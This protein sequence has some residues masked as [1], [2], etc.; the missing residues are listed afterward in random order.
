MSATAGAGHL[1]RFI[2]R[3]ERR[4]LPFWL[5]GA[6][7]VVAYQ[8]IGSQAIYDTPEKLA[9][10]Q[11]TFGGNPAMVA[12]AGP[13]E[14]LATIGGEV[15]FEMFAYLAIL[16]A[17]MNMFLVGRNTRVEEETGRVELI[18]STQ[19]GRRAPLAAALA[20]A[21]LS[22]VSLALLVFLAAAGTGLPVSGSALLGVAAAS[23]GIFFAGLTAVAVQVFESARAAY[24]AVAAALGLAFFLRA[25]GDGGDGTASW[26][27]PIGWGQR[28][29]PFVAD[30]WWP[31]VLPL[32]ISAALV[33]VAVALLDRRDVG[34]GLVAA[35][36]GPATASRVL[37]TP[38]GLAV[39]L[40]RGPLIGWGIGLLV[41]GIAYGSFAESIEQ[42]IVDNPDIAEIF[43][44]ASGIVD[45]YLGFT[46][47]ALALLAGAYGISAA[48]R[49]RSEET[50]GRAEP[51]LATRTSR[52]SWLASHTAVAL[53]GS[54]LVLAA[55]GL[56]Q[57]IAYAAVTSNG[58]QVARMVGVAM[59]FAPAMCA[60]V[61]LAV[62]G[63][64]LLPRAAAAV[65]WALFGACAFIEVFGDLVH[66]PNWVRQ[67]SPFTHTPLAP[68]E[69]VTVLPLAAITAVVIVLLVG[70]FGGLRRRDFGPG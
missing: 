29:F 43:G 20:V 66:L 30:R 33:A 32:V 35:R 31:L 52:G 57:G 11:Q 68:A 47:M 69:P 9:N 40:Q 34:A 58:G 1:V 14:L 67:L 51:V 64:G 36:P 21:G 19:V 26:F 18:R 24:G 28:T 60:L 55:G 16:V 27:S 17:L 54:V 12:F 8:S 37:G 70:G 3:R 7:L 62:L 42:F 61:A 38:L 46:T 25:A 56:G 10:L 39:R 59:V 50:S 45:G 13:R 6:A 23:V 15:V 65:A 49:A 2:L 44:G 4:A 63:F 41:N 53:G 48:L 22:N 5:G